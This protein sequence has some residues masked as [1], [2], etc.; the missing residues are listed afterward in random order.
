MIVEKIVEI[1][2]NRRLTVDVPRE[3]P[4]GKTILV[5]KPVA[6]SFHKLSAQDAINLGLGLSTNIRIDPTEAIKR[7]S[8]IS[9]RLGSK[10]SSND[11]LAMCRKDKEFEEK[12]KSL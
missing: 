8:G 12:R 5:F 4:A 11:F 3:V 7:C 9:K 2:S 1:P 6:E 10:F